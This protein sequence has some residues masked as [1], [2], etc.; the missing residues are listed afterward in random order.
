MRS[1]HAGVHPAWTL[2][3]VPSSASSGECE[4]QVP[5][6]AEVRGFE[7]IASSTPSAPAG[8]ARAALPCT[9]AGEGV[10]VLEG[11]AGSGD[12][13]GDFTAGELEALP[14]AAAAS[15]LPGFAAEGRRVGGVMPKVDG[16]LEFSFRRS[17]VKEFGA[18]LG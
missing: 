10:P 7:T 14:T 18:S 9:H 1:G 2:Q 15:A 8:D 11:I 6:D 4:G 12:F 13:D 17:G 3:F 5:N 16:V